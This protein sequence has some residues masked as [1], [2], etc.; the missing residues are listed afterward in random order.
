MIIVCGLCGFV[1]VVISTIIIC[2]LDT[3]ENSHVIRWC[4]S[5]YANVKI[6]I[7]LH[8]RI[9]LSNRCF[10]SISMCRQHFRI[11]SAIILLRSLRG[12][13]PLLNFCNFT[14]KIVQ[15]FWNQ[16]RLHFNV[17]IVLRLRCIVHMLNTHKFFLFFGTYNREITYVVKCHNHCNNSRMQEK[18]NWRHSLWIERKKN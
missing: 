7:Q 15:L 6:D 16:N 14:W 10:R 2:T 8:I 17:Q 13:P 18:K 5:L 12:P 9:N 11:Y 4:E 1:V 3:Y